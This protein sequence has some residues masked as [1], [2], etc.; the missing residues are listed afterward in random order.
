[1]VIQG[2]IKESDIYRQ[3]A[4][5]CRQLAE[6]AQDEA[7]YKRF[8]RMEAAWL[9][10][11]EEQDWLDVERSPL[12]PGQ[13]EIGQHRC[14]LFTLH[15][16]LATVVRFANAE[17][18]IDVRRDTASWASITTSWIISRRTPRLSNAAKLFAHTQPDSRGRGT[19]RSIGRSPDRAEN[20][21]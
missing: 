21:H 18:C 2:M 6:A 7:A 16:R 8:K 14:C 17:Q 5:N 12:D 9:A 20:G 19:F 1:M 15:A 11:A 3:N 10:L 13:G 4:D